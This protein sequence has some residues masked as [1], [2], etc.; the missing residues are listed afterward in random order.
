M[1]THAWL[2][3]KA[4]N[5]RGS[6][7]SWFPHAQVN[8]PEVQRAVTRNLVNDPAFRKL[9]MDENKVRA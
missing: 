8:Q 1:P 3:Q 7:V 2:S 6:E 4:C 5:S 9:I